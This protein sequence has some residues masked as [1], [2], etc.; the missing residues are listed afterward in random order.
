MQAELA[1]GVDCNILVTGG[2]SLSITAL[3]DSPEEITPEWSLDS[4]DVTGGEQQPSL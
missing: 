1:G 4:I 2:L 3:H